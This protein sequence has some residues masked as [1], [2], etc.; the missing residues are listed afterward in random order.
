MQIEIKEEEY[1]KL[2]VHYEA[3]MATT[4]LKKSEI[5]TRFKDRRV[6]GFRP[7]KAPLQAITNVF[8]KQIDQEL[9]RELTVDAYHKTVF[10]KN[11]KPLGNPVFTK[12][13][14]TDKTFFCDFLLQVKPDFSLSAYKE[15]EL[16]KMAHPYSNTEFAEKMLQ[17]L[18]LKHGEKVQ[19]TDSDFIENGDDVIIDYEGTID[20]AAVENLNVKGELFT[21]GKSNVPE[22]DANILGM[23]LGEEREFKIK[24]DQSVL[25]SVVGKEVVFKTKLNMGSKIVPM[26]LGDELAQ[27]VGLPD[28]TSLRQNVESVASS[29]MQDEEV[30]HNVQQV[31]VRLVESHDFKVPQWLVLPEAELA[32]KSN[33]MDWAKLSDEDREKYLTSAEKSIKLS[34]VLDKV[35]ESE[36]ATQLSDEELITMV[37][38]NVA[39]MANGASVD[40][41]L[42]QLQ[43]SGYLPML[44]NRVRDQFTL[45]FL[46]KTCKVIE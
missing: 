15:F 4:S 19:Y 37:K 36:P 41:L 33:K 16:P 13:E 25:P 27:K 42:D 5:I 28:F 8:R 11:L 38:Q 21:V 10:E 12:M 35:R 6:P 34:L 17:E 45:E 18:R 9:V 40:S 14:L 32:C 44:Y 20:G 22:F 1:C 23:K 3:D 2:N 39:T 26:P 31:S 43:K 30:K 29:R 7:G 46:A 24:F